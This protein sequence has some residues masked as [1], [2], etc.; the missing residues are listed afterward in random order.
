MQ[1][2]P[3]EV[4]QGG[5]TANLAALS[6]ACPS[7]DGQEW[8]LRA[9]APHGAAWAVVQRAQG[10]PGA[11]QQVKGRRARAVHL[12]PRH[13]PSHRHRAWVLD[14]GVPGTHFPYRLEPSVFSEV[15]LSKASI[16]E[17]QAKNF[18]S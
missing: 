11:A 18:P 15:L 9:C 2:D 7:K 10:S 5:A 13:M 16:S 4:C 1:T 8:F 6:P 3:K 14:L 17:A 12:A